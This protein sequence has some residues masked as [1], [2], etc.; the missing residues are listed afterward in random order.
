MIDRGQA[1]QILSEMV[2]I[3]R[4]FQIAAQR[5]RARSLTGTKFRVLQQ[6]RRDDAR[7]GG[8]AEQVAVS[9]PVASR[10]VDSLEESGLVV[11][12]TDPEDARAC[13]ISITDHGRAYLAEREVPVVDMFAEALADFSPADAEQ[14]VE[15]LRR[16][17][18]HLAEVTEQH[19]SAARQQSA[20]D[21]GSDG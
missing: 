16:L 15:L 8:L 20:T 5:S 17:N 19:E 6:L 18:T 3:G 1:G 21:D 7:P 4:T 2:E 11:R 10:A 13:L 9:A 12:R 14:A